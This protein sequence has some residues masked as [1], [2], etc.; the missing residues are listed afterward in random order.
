MLQPFSLTARGMLQRVIARVTTAGL[1]ASVAQHGADTIRQE[2]RDFPSALTLETRDAASH[3][4]G[5]AIEIIAE[6][7]QGLAGFSALGERGKRI[8][9]V[10]AEACLA[11]QEWWKTGAACEEHLADH[12]VLPAALTLGESEWTT[13]HVTEH[14]R[15]VL[16]VVPQFL[17]VTVSLTESLDGTCIKLE[18]IG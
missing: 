14:L 16:W 7:E 18:Q 4:P 1:P 15:T 11:F 5:A 13:S 6:C 2:M 10:A 12:L 9:T 17:P 8:E 3:S